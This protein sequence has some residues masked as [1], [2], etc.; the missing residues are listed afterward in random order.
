VRSV[1]LYPLYDQ[2]WWH[3]S[4]ASGLVAWILLAVSVTWGLLVSTRLLGRRP[5]AAW[6]LDLHRFVGGLALAFTALHLA[7]LVADSYVHFGAADLLVPFAS[8]WRPA[9]VAWGVVA[10]WLLV[11]VELTSLGM[12]RLPRRV[13]HSVHLTSLPLLLGATVHGLTA[14][15]DAGSRI[16][17]AVAVLLL[18]AAAGLVLFRLGWSRRGRGGARIP[19][20]AR[21]E[22]AA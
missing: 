11:A 16:Y 13:W 18:A 15:T 6:T 21:V 2:V 1:A 12:R 3:L 5:G 19:D 10:F 17:R 22:V 8:S 9:A 7:G 14:G 20:A 4:R